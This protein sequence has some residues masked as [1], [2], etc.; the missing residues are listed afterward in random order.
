MLNLISCWFMCLVPRIKLDFGFIYVVIWFSIR[1]VKSRDSLQIFLKVLRRRGEVKNF[2]DLLIVLRSSICK[3]CLFWLFESEFS[4]SPCVLEKV[5]D[6]VLNFGRNLA[7]TVELVDLFGVLQSLAAILWFCT[8]GVKSR[9]S[10]L[11]FSKYF[12]TP[13]MFSL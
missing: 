8:R 4:L 9:R 13:E 2:A 11:I 3:E 10:L 12:G 5:S 1:G 7:C 6:N